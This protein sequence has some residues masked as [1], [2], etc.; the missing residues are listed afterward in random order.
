MININAKLLSLYI[1]VTNCSIDIGNILM[2]MLCADHHLIYF[3]IMK[4]NMLCA[5]H[6]L[7]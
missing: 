7:I 2:L 6:M 4:A 3:G 5:V 1:H